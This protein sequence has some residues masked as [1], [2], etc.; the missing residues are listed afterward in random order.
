MVTYQAPGV[1]VEEVPSGSRPIEAVGTAVAAFVGFA[2]KGPIGQAIRV[3]NWT[4]Y[5]ATF[6]GLMANAY[7]PLS[8]YGFFMNGGGNCYVIRVGGDAE[9]RAA[10]LAL[11]GRGAQE[12]LFFSARELGAP[13]NNITVEIQDEPTPPPPE[14]GTEAPPEPDSGGRFRVTVRAPGREPEVFGDLSLRRADS[15][16]AVDQINA[17]S[18]L[19]FVEDRAQ[20]GVSVQSRQPV[21]GAFQLT[22]GGESV[23][24]LVPADFQ[25]SVV[26]RRGI[27]GLEAMGD[28]TMIAIPD[29][30]TAF[31]QGLVDEEGVISVQKGLLAHCERMEN[32][33]AILD[34]PSGLTAQQA[35]EWRQR[36]NL[37]S[38]GGYGALYYP[39]IKVD[40]PASGSTRFVPPSGHVAGVWARTDGQRGVHKAPANMEVLGAIDVQQRLTQTELGVLNV[41]SIN[42][43]RPVPGAGIRVWGARTL[44]G[45]AS[46]WRYLNVRRLFNM[47]K[48]SIEQGTQWVPFEPNDP[49]LWAKVRRDVTAFLTRIWGQ[50]ALFGETA[51]EAFYVKCD[52]ET[53]PQEVID[54]GI[55]VCEIGIAPVKPAEFVVFRIQQI[56]PG[57]SEG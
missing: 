35:E 28:V 23:T 32:R 51:A 7:M 19:V 39:W 16:Y 3:T 46:E 55:M 9:P 8:V 43:I 29:L 24:A 14:A 34:M 47:V 12:S 41:Q 17:S 49:T 4:Q 26:E 13:G 42:V 6:G 25:G 18:T 38:D 15:R 40:D 45:S 33:V 20:R 36:A 1:Y 27:D 54:A 22:A 30:M 31:E 48:E 53:N 5:Q 52:R 21:T 2:E 11:P 57:S 44:A 10:Q 37:A 56:T 50:G